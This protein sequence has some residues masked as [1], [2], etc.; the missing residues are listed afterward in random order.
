MKTGRGNNKW[1]IIRVHIFMFHETVPKEYVGIDGYLMGLKCFSR[2]KCE[3]A[4]GT[5][6]HG[7]WEAVIMLPQY[8]GLQ[9]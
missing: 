7:T 4:F 5:L 3:Q 8:M 2:D 6:G 9:N 1:N